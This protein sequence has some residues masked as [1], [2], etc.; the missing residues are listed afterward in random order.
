MVA[1][2]MY[3]VQITVDYSRP[4][5]YTSATKWADLKMMGA[6]IKRTPAA[7]TK[8]LTEQFDLTSL[9]V[10]NCWHPSICLVK[11]EGYF[12]TIQ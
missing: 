12:F 9:H 5:K 6:N 7:S 2:K 10:Y 8:G 3:T 11:R 1:G 4:N